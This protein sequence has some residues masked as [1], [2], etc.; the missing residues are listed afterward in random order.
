MAVPHGSGGI[1][2]PQAIPGVKHII[3]VASGKGGVGKSTTAVNLAVCLAA[4]KKSVGILDADIYGPSIPGLLG[5]HGKAGVTDDKKLIP[6]E[7]HGIRAMSVGFLVDPNQAMVWRG[8]MVMGAIE[9]FCRQVNW[10]PLDILVIDLPPGTGD[11]HLSITQ[12][13]PLDG[14]VIVS[15]PQEIALMDVRRGITMFEKV[16]VPVYGLVENMSYFQCSC[17][18]KFYIFGEGGCKKLAEE[19]GVDVLGSVPLTVNI[20]KFADEGTPIS[21]VEP[22]NARVYEE[23]AH[24]VIAKLGDKATGPT[25]SIQ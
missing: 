19:L 13:V 22:E 7:R 3:A 17:D 12:R 2:P 20:R 14:A 25:I 6:M 18:Q 4:Q 15:T 11:A 23:I 1:N 5:I 24:K 16:N 8:P 10:G 21:L 9:Q